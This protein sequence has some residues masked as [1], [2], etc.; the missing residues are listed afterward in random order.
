MGAEVNSTRAV[1]VAAVTVAEKV[2]YPN[3]DFLCNFRIVCLLLSVIAAADMAGTVNYVLVYCD[4]S[5]ICC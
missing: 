2:L 5:C 4:G 1:V 3:F